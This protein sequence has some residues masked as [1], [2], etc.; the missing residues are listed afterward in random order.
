MDAAEWQSFSEAEQAQLND[1]AL[2]DK[3]N[4]IAYEEG[5]SR[6][7]VKGAKQK[8]EERQAKRRTGRFQMD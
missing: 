2:W 7:Q 6:A 4:L 1:L 5:E 8:R 3:A